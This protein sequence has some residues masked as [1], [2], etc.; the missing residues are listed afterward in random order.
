MVAAPTIEARDR[1]FWLAG[2]R[3]DAYH[4][5]DLVFDGRPV[6]LTVGAAWCK[7]CVAE[8][9]ELIAFAGELRKARNGLRVVLVSVDGSGGRSGLSLAVE[10]LLARER[11]LNPGLDE[12][13]LPAWLELRSDPRWEWARLAGPF[14]PPLR[15]SGIPLAMLFDGCGNLRLLA[16]ERLDAEALSRVRDLALRMSCR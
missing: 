14:V 12:L 3:H 2:G 16:Q 6:L 9:R 7:P 11:A 13:I 5:G 4:E 8:L 1:G 10:D 15:D